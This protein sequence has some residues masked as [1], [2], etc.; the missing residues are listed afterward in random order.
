MARTLLAPWA[1]RTREEQGLPRDQETGP[2]W[3]AGEQGTYFLGMRRL[4]PTVLMLTC[5][6]ES[7]PSVAL[8]ACSSQHHLLTG[9]LPAPSPPCSLYIQRHLPKQ[10]ALSSQKA[11]A[12]PESP[13]RSHPNSR[14]VS[15]HGGA[16][17]WGPQGVGAA[18]ANG[19]PLP[20]QS[21]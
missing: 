3:S 16:S 15:S 11:G 6:L 4:P 17:E 21:I 1:G 14:R 19:H 13:R 18:G 2:H 7:S 20:V 5:L 8:L 12:S 9:Q 10:E